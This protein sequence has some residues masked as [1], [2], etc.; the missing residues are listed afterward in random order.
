VS[1]SETKRQAVHITMVGWAFLLRVLTWPQA[2]ALAATALFVNAVVLPRAGGRAIFRPD[3]VRKGIPAGIL[4]YPI[5]VLLLILCFRNRLDIAAAAWA[6][7]AVGDG[8]ATLV[9]RR[10]DGARLPWNADKT[11]AGTAACAATG[12]AAGVLLCWW[13]QPNVAP[14]APAWFVVA[15]PLVAAIVAA[16]V[17]TIPVRLDDNLSVPFAAGATLWIMSLMDAATASAMLPGAMGR[18]IPAVLVNAGFAAIAFLEGAVTWPGVFAGCAVGLAVYLGAGWEGWLMLLATFVAAV[19]TSKVGWQRKKALGIE[20]D[21]EGRRGAGNALAN[22]LV[23]AIAGVVAITSPYQA[24]AWLAL[25]TA[26]TAGAADTV[27]SEIGKAWGRRTFLVVGFRPV[28]PGTSGAISLEGTIANVVAAFALAA[29]GA[30]LGLIPTFAIPHVAVGAL[31]GSFVES[32]L[33]ATL[34]K[35]GILNN[36]LLNF[37]ATAVAVAVTL[38]TWNLGFIGVF[39]FGYRM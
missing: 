28:P 12:G 36:D 15:A 30:A 2:A 25:V 26:L 5:A 22:C 23:G 1:F 11:W 32:A 24:A 35:P 18:L 10:V 3:D 13:T 9:G 38:T 29:L 20:E 14:P 39:Q 31:A 6:I 27:A 4:Y 19:V 8:M 34:E 7:L 16:F 33:G 21:R 17:E 37:I